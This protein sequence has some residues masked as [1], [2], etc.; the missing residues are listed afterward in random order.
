MKVKVK[1][2]SWKLKG[3]S[4]AEYERAKRL[5][6]KTGTPIDQCPTCKGK[7]E[8]IP[9]SGG[10]TEFQSGSYKNRDGEVIECDCASQMALRSR[11]LLAN[12]GSQYQKL[13]WKDFSP[14]SPEIKQAVDDYVENW[15]SFLHHGFGI[16]LGGQDLGVGKTF[17]ATYIGKEMIK[18]NQTVY[19]IPFTDLVFAYQSE[20]S[21]LEDKFRSVT[22]LV[23]DEV[24]LPKTAKQH[25]VF[26][27]K[28]EAM[29]RHRTNYDLPTIITTNVSAEKLD[30][31]YPRVYSLLAAKQIRVEFEGE[32]AR[33]KKGLENSEMIMNDMRRPIT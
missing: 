3:L 12:I 9:G 11:Y 30:G 25:E 31:A 29:I 14:K 7:R 13:D 33:E 4:D 19:F 28:F 1:G 24:T 15:E 18:R 22:F 17:S 5:A 10:V 20:D 21:D 27:D 23:I 8:A 26:A 2:K 6:A 16:E 32:D